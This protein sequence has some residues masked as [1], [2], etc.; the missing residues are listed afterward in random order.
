MVKK[1]IFSAKIILKNSNKLKRIREGLFYRMRLYGY[2]VNVIY[3]NINQRI[4]QLFNK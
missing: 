2:I 3:L 1:I 4:I